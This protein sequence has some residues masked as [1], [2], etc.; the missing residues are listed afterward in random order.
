MK[1][2]MDLIREILTLINDD[3]K[4]DGMQE[5]YYRTAEA[6]GIRDHSNEEVAYHL[7]L[8]IESCYV[9][10]AVSPVLPM[11]VRKLTMRGHD[12]LGSISDPGI[13]KKTKERLK[14][15]PGVALPIVAEVA[16]A[17]LKKRLGLG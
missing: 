15:L 9:D 2:D 10:G 3:P 1:R 14:D 5:F 4:Y 7:G 13:W 11:V 6:F 12:F 16:S 8:L 17:E